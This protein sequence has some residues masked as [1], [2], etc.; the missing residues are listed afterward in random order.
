MLFH[1][2][3]LCIGRSQRHRRRVNVKAYALEFHAPPDLRKGF[4]PLLFP[5]GGRQKRI[6]L[7]R[8]AAPQAGGHVHGL[9]RGLDHQRTA[10]AERVLRQCVGI[11][12]AQ[13]NDGRG[14]RLLD[15]RLHTVFAVTA[16][17]QAVA[18]GIQHYLHHIFA[19]GKTYFVQRAVLWQNLHPVPALEPLHH[20][21][22]HDALTGRNAGKRTGQT[23]ALHREL[24]VRGQQLFPGNGRYA[25]KQ[26][27]KG[28][29]LVGLK[30]DE[31]ALG[32][33]APQI[34][35]CDDVRPAAERHA[36]ICDSDILCA[37]ALKVERRGALCA[38]IAGC[39]QIIFQNC[40]PRLF[41]IVSGQRP[42]IPQAGTAV[43]AWGQ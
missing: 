11:D 16:L 20:S 14:Q 37:D 35:G 38:K 27:V 12:A 24:R 8:K 2:R 19:D 6:V 5:D 13:V 41:K 9:H 34:G 33:A 30:Q 43:T 1:S 25:V 28:N 40:F 4:L 23:T 7:R 42:G 36:S 29:G 22:F 18:G 15:G 32:T 21:L 31:H 26:L 39:D 3:Q 10:A 17:V